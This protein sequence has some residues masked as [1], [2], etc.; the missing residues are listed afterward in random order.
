M[1]I[2]PSPKNE[3]PRSSQRKLRLSWLDGIT[4]VVCITVVGWNFKQLYRSNGQPVEF[5][6]SLVCP[7][8]FILIVRCA[9]V[10]LAMGFVDIFGRFPL[11]RSLRNGRFSVRSIFE[12]T[13]VLAVAMAIGIVGLQDSFAFVVA[14]AAT[15][16]VYLIVRT[17]VQDWHAPSVTHRVHAPE[18]S[19]PD[20]HPDLDPP[21]ELTLP[22]SSD[23]EKQEE[24]E[25]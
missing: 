6:L 11:R 22:I 13:G 25:T 17:A 7:C 20:H 14:L 12:A 3:T 18:E 9:I 4:I 2:D 16:T 10:I 21:E 24:S 8:F 1:E 15:A 5:V 23:A 19:N